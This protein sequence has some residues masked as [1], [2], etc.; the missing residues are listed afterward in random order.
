MTYSALFGLIA[1]GMKKNFS[2]YPEPF[3]ETWRY[4][5]K[6]TKQTLFLPNQNRKIV[7]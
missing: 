1:K 7:S 5:G 4:K 2:V 3:R 6:G